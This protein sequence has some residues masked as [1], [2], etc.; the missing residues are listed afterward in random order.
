MNANAGSVISLFLVPMLT[1]ILSATEAVSEGEEGSRSKALDERRTSS[2]RPS[3]G[4]L[5]DWVVI[6]PFSAPEE[7][8]VSFAAIDVREVTAAD[9][10]QHAGKEHFWTYTVAKNGAPKIDLSKE[11]GADAAGTAYAAAEVYVNRDMNATLR[12]ETRE[13][14][15][16]WLDGEAVKLGPKAK[17]G[18][19]AY[20]VPIR[21]R[22]GHNE[23][24]IGLRH[25]KGKWSFSARVLDEKGELIDPKRLRLLADGINMRSPKV[26]FDVRG[27]S[28]ILLEPHSP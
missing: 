26:H 18:E 6:G 20:V 23:I 28:D 25:V 8:G 21:L 15:A 12:V 4:Y 11:F 2:I 9:S 22:M 5:V 19:R 14:V 17:R 10:V 7:S 13:K 3:D 16:C 1:V 24:V 27:G